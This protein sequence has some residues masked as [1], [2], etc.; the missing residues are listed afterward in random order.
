MM[1]KLLPLSFLL[2]MFG[3]IVLATSTSEAL[4][5]NGSLM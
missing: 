2:V 3:L 1:G 4:W 5:A